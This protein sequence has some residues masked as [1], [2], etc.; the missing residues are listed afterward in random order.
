MVLHAIYLGIWL[1]TFNIFQRDTWKLVFNKIHTLENLKIF[2]TDPAGF[3]ERFLNQDEFLVHY[4]QPETINAV[5]NILLT[6]SKEG[7]KC[8]ICRES[9]GLFLRCK[10]HYAYWLS[11]KRATPPMQIII[12]TCRG[13]YESLSS[14]NSEE[15]EKN[16]SSFTRT[17]F[18]CTFLI[19]VATVH[20]CDFELYLKNYINYLFNFH[21]FSWEILFLP[22][23]W[24]KTV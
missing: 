18:Q 20:Y 1:E 3:I 13:S 2:E 17:I 14:P 9:D 19:S 6:V 23:Q 8:F 4:I 16:W 12:P 5:E 15:N 7:Q 24:Q 21:V 11:S 10:S 22:D